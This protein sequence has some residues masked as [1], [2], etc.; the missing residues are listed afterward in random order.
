MSLEK[1]RLEL[2]VAQLPV[3]F[4]AVLWSAFSI[5]AIWIN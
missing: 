5:F 4:F 2:Q 3:V 1:L